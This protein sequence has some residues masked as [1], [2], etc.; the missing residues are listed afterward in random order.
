MPTS[1]DNSPDRMH[2]P[3]N[4]ANLFSIRTISIAAFI[5]G[6]CG[7]QFPALADSIK[8]DNDVAAGKTLC[9][10]Q[11]KGNC[12]A[13]H[14]IQGGESPGN[15]GPRL[16]AIQTRFSDRKA[17]RDQIWDAM[18]RNPETSMPPFGRHHILSEHEIDQIVT[19]LWTL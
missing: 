15:I 17:L 16:S 2:Q 8:E 5:I 4:A 1:S 11:L 7:A 3:Q 6:L 13:C 10:D 12:L 19:F 14:A 18:I 9:F